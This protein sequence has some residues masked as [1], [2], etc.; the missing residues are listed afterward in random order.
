MSHGCLFVWVN[1]GLDFELTAPPPDAGRG[2]S[3]R[4]YVIWHEEWCSGVDPESSRT[5]TYSGSAVLVGC[6]AL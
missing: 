3:K 6:A 4:P 2:E 1:P 5:F